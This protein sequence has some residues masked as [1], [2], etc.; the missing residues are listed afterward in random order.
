MLT[1]SLFMDTH[2]TTLG[3]AATASAA[4]IKTQYRKLA[5]VN[6]PDKG[7]DTEKFKVIQ[8]AYDILGD[9]NKRAEY[10]D[11]LAHP[12]RYS[13]SAQPGRGFPPGMEEMMR[14]FG[15]GSDS[16]GFGSDFNPGRHQ[17][18]K[19]NRDMQVQLV[20]DMASSL[21]AQT[22]I[23]NLQTSA[24][25]TQSVTVDI[26]RG[27]QDGST[28]RY[29]GLG[30]N[31]IASLPPGDLHVHIRIQP[32][33]NYQIHGIDLLGSIDITCL[34]AIIG[35]T[36]EFVSFDGSTYSLTVPEGTQGGTKFKI[37]NKG[38]HAPNSDQRGNLYL[39]VRI[40]V[41]TNL[42]AAQKDIIRQLITT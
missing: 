10:D 22:K 8:T 30:D 11:K 4:E 6:H 16:F 39:E 33:A 28:I 20:I 7:G 24:G 17:A 14:G 2:Y 40:I 18:P 38:L 41:P 34:N 35:C 19:R 1:Q 15:F 27:I 32:H 23:F 21:S 25:K 29:S 9:A 26:P 37:A 5:S 42:T 13:N 31:S 3:V 36:Q 12:N